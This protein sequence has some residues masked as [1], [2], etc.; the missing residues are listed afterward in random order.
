M[1]L[2][3]QID[4]APGNPALILLNGLFA[5]LQ[6]WER[7]M[8]HLRDFYVLRFDGRGQGQSPKPA[9][10]YD[11]E[12]QV[13]D[14]LRLLLELDWPPCF[15]V[16]ISHGGSLGLEFA[17]RCPD[18]VK[19]L[20]AAD[21]H[22]KTTPLMALKLKSWLA[23]HHVGGPT[24][25]FDVAAPWIWSESVMHDYPAL[26]EHYRNKAGD[27]E[28]QA[29]RGLIEGALTVNINVEEI[30]VPVMLLAGEED[31]LTPPFFM[32]SMNINQ[33]QFRTT[34][35][36]HASLLEQPDIFENTIVPFLKGL[37]HAE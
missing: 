31:V 21:C 35:G 36:G 19:A 9:E 15:L 17:R 23:A 4:G 28:E 24:H 3:Y 13:Q 5:D 32:K 11:L 6:S 1:K 22:H 12:T 7:G 27:H 34:P 10:V 14:L 33:C 26:I 25:R 2:H 37:E 16:G 8:E 18:R 20:V 29:V 30:R